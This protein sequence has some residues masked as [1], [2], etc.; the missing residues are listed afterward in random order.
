MES[1]TLWEK[2]VAVRGTATVVMVQGTTE[3]RM[4]MRTVGA[5]IVTTGAPQLGTELLA[6]TMGRQIATVQ[7]SEDRVDHIVR[8]LL[9]VQKREARAE[10]SFL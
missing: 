8:G 9:Q 3:G 2:H 4:M 6:A 7:T 10:D 5:T 1:Q